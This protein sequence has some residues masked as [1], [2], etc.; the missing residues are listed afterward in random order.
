MAMPNY[1]LVSVSKHSHLDLC[2]KHAMAGF[3]NSLAGAWTFVEIQEGDFI[4]FLYAAKAFNLYKVIH[5]KAISDFAKDSLW[6]SVTFRVSGRTYHFPFRLYLQP[7]R[8][9]CESLVRPEFAYVAENLLLRAGYRKTHFQAD[10]TTLQNVSQMGSLWNG[11]VGVWD[12]SPHYTFEPLFTLDRKKQNIPFVCMFQEIILQSAVRRYLSVEANLAAFLS[13][14]GFEHLDVANFEVLGEKALGEGHI[15]ILVKD[16][17]PIARARKIII[18]CK[19]R[20]SQMGDLSQLE[21]YKKELGEECIGGILISKT[22][23]ESVIS[24]AKQRRIRLFRYVL[25]LDLKSPTCFAEILGN[26]R[27][28]RVS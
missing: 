28:E 22:F 14:A 27:L 8:Q 19:L 6:P 13:A 7:I 1:F 20:A 4:S 10:Q 25:D 9:F 26:L 2:L 16:R 18:E 12:S 21:D 15:D 17:V 23:P 11:D 5:K 24:S 3:T